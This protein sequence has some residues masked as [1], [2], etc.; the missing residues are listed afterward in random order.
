MPVVEKAK[1]EIAGLVSRALGQ[2]VAVKAADLAPPPNKEMGDLSFACFGV[3]K[4]LK[5]SPV[6]AA[7]DIAAAIKPVGLV[8]EVAA[9]GPYVNFRL[10]RVVFSASVISEALS[11]PAAFGPA[12]A[13]KG[14]KIMVEYAQPNTHKEFHVG[15]LRNVCLG[16]ATV[17][18][19]RA[20]GY[21]VVPVSYMGDIGA[22]VAKCLWCLKK[23]HAGETPPDNK[24]KYLGQ[25]YAEAT[26]RV[27]EDEKLKDEVAE[28]Q[29]KLEAREPEWTKL[30]EETRKWSIGE[31]EDI[32]KELGIELDRWYWE[33]EVEEP[34]KKLVREL[35]KRGL[36]EEGERGAIIINLEKYGLGVFLLLKSDGN[37]LY[38]TKELALAELKFSE[39]KGISRSI[40]IVDSRQSLYFKQ[41]FKTLELMGFD[42]LKTTHL[43]YE[44]VTLKEGAMSS[45][46]GNIVAYED[47]RD[48]MTARAAEET[49]KRR[50]DW[51]EKRIKE[52]AW[53]VAEG[54]M[55]FGMLKQD[56]DKPIVFDIESALSFDGFTGPY[57]QYVHA[58]LSSILAKAG[59]LPA[60][61][62][63]GSA[64][65][66]EHFVLAAAARFP[67]AVAEA[68]EKYKPSIL[69]QYLFDLAQ[70]ANDY[71]RDV[72]V[73]SAAGD[74]R[75]HR[76]QIVEAVRITLKRGLGLLGVKAPAEM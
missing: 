11:A 37:S 24:G 60:G 75:T 42:K 29:R 1:N 5:K 12:A 58:R 50:D 14:E 18:L 40:H 52:T 67:E 20:V 62:I 76:L 57:I 15:H 35:L 68:A 33:S 54:A 74:E 39:Y 4:S 3:A 64:D 22:H 55:K 8:A 2:A 46:K 21:E 70:A 32:F 9:A 72:P 59:G 31:F 13:E 56:P 43:A 26:R 30:W 25:I 6:E 66:A 69:A 23:F 7:K 41:F 19:C 49:K 63:R 65:E 47:F 45:R 71:Y 17:D 73:L 36:A 48:E 44:F 51:D 16:Q 53:T 34:G 38:S 28:V 10:D 61:D 27:D